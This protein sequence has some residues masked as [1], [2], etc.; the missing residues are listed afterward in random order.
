MLFQWESSLN[1]SDWNPIEGATNQN[2]NPP[3]STAGQIYY[4]ASL[5]NNGAACNDPESNSLTVIVNSLP[6]GSISG[7][8]T[9][10]NGNN[11]I[12]S[13]SVTGTGPWNGTLSD[14]TPFNSNTSPISVSV[15]PTSTTTYSIN[16]LRDALCSA[17]PTELSGS[18]TVTV[19]PISVGGSVNGSTSVCTGTNSTLLTLSGQIG[20]VVM[21]QFSVD[22]GNNWINDANTNTTY[23]ASN[24]TTTTQ[25]RVVIQSGICPQAFSSAATITVNPLLPVSVSIAASANPICVGNSVTFTAT[26]TNGG[27]SPTYRWQ[28]NGINVPGEFGSTF[29][30]LSITSGTV[31]TALLTSNATC[32]SQVTA[33]S[34][35]ISLIINPIPATPTASSNSPVCE[36]SSI[37]LFTPTVTGASYSWTGPNGFT[38][39]VQNPTISSSTIIMAGIYRV[40]VT[41]NG[42]TSLVGTTSVIINAIPSTP[43][44]SSNSPVCA[45]SIINLTTPSVAGATYSWTGP[46]GFTSANQNPT[47]ANSTL[48]MAGLYRVTVTVTGCPSLA[49]TTT[50]AINTIPSTPTASSNSPLCAGS[51]LN[52][53][54]SLVAG[55]TYFWTGPNGFTSTDQNP[56]IAT[57]TPSMAGGY[58]VTAIING[59]PSPAGTTSVVINEIPS[60][61]T[62]SSNSPVCAGSTINLT[63][64]SVAGATYSWTGPNGFTSTIQNPTI[65]NSTLAMAGLYS[66]TVTVNGC[67]SLAGTTTVAINTIPSTPTASSNS[68]LCAGSTLNLTS[69][70]VAG[71]TYSWTGPNGFTSANQNPTIANSTLA[72]AGVYSVTAI[73]N[74]CPSPAVTTSVVINA[75]PS[76]PTAS[77]NSPVCT[78]STINLTTPLVA[79]ATYSWTGPNGFT[80]TIQNPTIANSTLAMAGLYSVTVTVNGCPSLAGTTTVAINTIP[81]TPTASSNSPLC[82]GST[83]NLTSSLV[84]GA[85]YSWTGPNGFT[86]TNQNPTIANSTLAMAGVY[87][88]TATVNGC[89][90]LAGTTSVV[91][92]E[93]PS[94][95]TVS[96]NSPVCAGSTINLTT[97]SVT[98]ASYSWTAPNGFTSTNQNPTIANAT[99]A[100]AGLYSVTVTVNGCPSTTGTTSLVVNS[101][102]TP[103]VTISSSSTSIC[104]FAGTSVTFTAIPV[105]GGASPSYQWKNG[106]TNVGP[107]SSTYTVTSLPAGSVISVVMT[108]NATCPSPTTATSNSIALTVY[109]GVPSTPTTPSVTPAPTNICPPAI[110]SLTSSSTNATLYTWTLPTPGWNIVA[111]NGTNTITVDITGAALSGNNQNVYVIASNA[112][113]SSSASGDKKFKVGNSASVD[114]GID[115]NVCAGNSI[116]VV[117]TLLGISDDANW[118]APSGSFSNIVKTTTTISATYTPSISSGTI[119]L[120]LTPVNPG[121]TCSGG[122]NPDVMVVTVNSRPTGVLSGT[123]AICN[124]SSATLS[125]A[126]TGSGTISGT[127]SDGTTFSGTAPTIT[128]NVSPNTT[129]TYTI[130]TLTNGTCPSIAADRTGSATVTVNNRPTA[131]ISGTQAICNG[132][133]ATLSLA[134]TGS[135][136][137]SG[138]LSD[139]TTFSGTAPTITVNV[140]P[141]TTTTYTITTLTNGTCPSI[142]ADRTG[143]ATV[144]VNNR[145]TAILSGTQAICN[146]SSATL[147]LAVTGSGTI[148]GTL[149]DGTTFSGTAPTITINVSPNT[150]TTYTITTLTNGTCPSI[151]AD[152]TGSATVTVNN[153]PTAIL[154]GTQAICNGSSATLSLA[155]TGSGT[156]SG[157]LSDGTTFSGTAPTITIN[158]SPNTT[159]TYTI[160]TLTNGTCPSIA[161]DRTGSATVTVNNRPTATLSG[162]QAICNGSSATLSLAV[163]GSGTI[164]GTLSD[165]TTFSGTA[166]TITVNVSP[167]TTTTYTITTLTNGT[168]PSIAADRT[169]SATVTVNNRP[170]ATLSGT[171]AICN[172]SSATLSLAVTG[173]G[174]ISGTLSDGTTFSGTAPTI[175]VNVSPNTTTTYTI[176]TLTNGTCPSIVADR[177]GSA[178][179][180]VNNRPTAILS[181]TQAICN[182]SSATLSLAVTGSGTISGTLSD[183]TTFSG[184][185]P[186]ISINVSPNTT[187]SYTIATLTNGTCPSIAADRTGSAI[188]TVNQPVVITTE[189]N[190]SQTVCSSFPVSFTV[191]ATGTGITYQWYKDSNPLSN[192]PGVISGATSATLTL[193]QASVAQSGTYYAIVTGSAPCTSATS[194]NAQLTVNR[195]IDITADPISQ[196]AC[197]GSNITFTVVAT[198]SISSYVW[199]KDG[200]PV[201]NGNYSGVSTA[202]LTITGVLVSN[203]GNYDVVISSSS[204]NGICDQV[205]SA[206]ALLV[207]NLPVE[208]PIF[209]LGASSTRCQG[210]GIITYTA[211][212][213][214]STS[215]TYSLDAITL[216]FA[217][218]SIVA[219]TGAVTFAAGWSGTSIITASAAGCNGPTSSS[220]TVTVTPTVGTPTA[221]TISAGIEP[222][223]QIT[224][225]T[226]TT[227]YAT[228]ATNNTG[229]NWTLSNSAAGTIN[230]SGIM[231][232]TSGFS[233]TVDIQVTADGCNGPSSQVIRTVNITPTVSLPTPI[234]VA[235]GSEPICQLTNGTTTTTYSTSAANSSGFNWSLSNPA[236]GSINAITGVM[237]W[238]NGFS[239]SVNIQVTANGCN[240]PSAQVI[241]TVNVTP[242]IGTPTAIIVS[243]G[244]EPTCQITASTPN[245]TY[246]TT[247]TNN[248]GFNWTLSN[249]AAGIINSSGVVTWAPGFSGPVDIQVTANGC[250]GPSSQVIRTVNISSTVSLPT[251]IVIAAGSEPIC[252]LTNGTTTTTYS[253]TASNS[254]GFNWSL[255]NPAAGS[256]NAITGLM[257]WANGFSGSV[258]IQVT[259]NGCNGP[260][261]QVIRTVNV[262]PTVGTPTAIAVA[263][264][265]E[266]ACQITSS[267]P[268]TTYSSTATGGTGF[269]WTV[270]NAAAGSIN[271]TTGVMTWTPGFS[272]SV[273]IQVTANGCNGPSGQVIRT[274]NITQSVANPIFVLG[275]SSARCQGAGSVTYTA[276]AT[277]SAGITYTLDAA[278]LSGGN[279]INGSTGAVSYSAAWSGT[280]TI[281]ASAAGCNGPITATHIVTINSLSAGGTITLPLT[282]VC[283]GSNSGTL[284]LS[285]NSGSIIRW[286]SSTNGGLNWSSITNTS[287]TQNYTNL[288]QTTSYR[289]VIQSGVCPIV[290]SSRAIV[291]IISP[292]TPTITTVP[293]PPVICEGQSATLTASTGTLDGGFSSG[294]FANANP[295][296]WRRDGQTTGDFLPAQ[297]DNSTSGA[298]GET[299]GPRIFSGTNYDSR[300]GKFAIVDGNRTSILETPIFSLIGISTATLDWRQAFNLLSGSTALV[301]LSVDGGVTYNII[302]APYI[303]PQS[304]GPSDGFLPYSIDLSPYLGQSNLRVRFNYTGTAGS[305]WA[306][307]DVVIGPPAPVTPVTYE[308]GTPFIGTG[309]TLTVSPIVTTTYTLTATLNGC[310]LGSTTVTVTVNP[311]PFVTGQTAT[312]CSGGTFNVTPTDGGGNK[313][314]AGTTY[315][316]T[317]PISSPVGAITGGSAQ[318]TGQNSISQTLTNTTNTPATLTYTVAP[319]SGV[320]VGTTFTIVVTVNPAPTIINQTA[321]ICSGGT[322]NVTPANGGGNIVPTGTIYSWSAPI[323]TGGITGGASGIGATNISGTLTNPTNTTQ[324]ATYSVTA[325]SGICAGLPFTVTVNVNPV[326]AINTIIAGTCTGSSFTVSPVNTTNG[327]VPAGTTYSWPAPIVTGGITGGTSGSGATNIS[328]TL[329]N[330]TNTPQTATYTVTPTTGS[331]TG[332]P[333][334]L[335][336]T[337][338]PLPVA[339]I[340][341]DPAIIYVNGSLS[342]NGNP[343]GGSGTYITHL[344]TGT[345]AIYLSDPNIQNPVF[346]GAPAGTYNLTYTV[347]DNN[348]CIGSDNVIITVYGLPT[349]AITPV[350]AVICADGSL[351][352]NG[353]PSGGSGTYTTH[354]WTGTGAGY[355]SNV[356]IQNPL[357]TGAP[358][359]TYT[360]TYTVT[361][362]AGGVGISATINVIVNR[363]PSTSPIYHRQI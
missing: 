325:T 205:V 224:A 194:A 276:S 309:Q 333:F 67:P 151:V 53:T 222:T 334:T 155:V 235:A 36:G 7:T 189:P 347:T 49:G 324:T 87:S 93:I 100:M 114:A 249:S 69:S 75:I 143:S 219:S 304:A 318:G 90:S 121:G 96:S 305:S 66:V 169:G 352:M 1:N 355:L 25:Y 17:G 354:L 45:S 308:W 109:N 204:G 142:A 136:T 115:Q 344:W 218:N 296:G 323:V 158:V 228:T 59:C 149:S 124:G 280:T 16:S 213:I 26:P 257:T 360:L 108:S 243:A 193:P 147:S 191:G 173:S 58:S 265:T 127:L 35:S 125:L 33:T 116:T 140:S 320:C 253:T 43:T 46:N 298:W 177:T 184:S 57:S 40:I 200:I 2:Y 240:G 275:S 206:P 292:F 190:P 60:T 267:T 283:S 346:S 27:I 290:Y 145:P 227:T 202:T 244:T 273:N 239:G 332:Q 71:A 164:S 198:G 97:P 162:T 120:T 34:N 186:T 351:N 348:G 261:A 277:N 180:T 85:T 342:F 306:I 130:T 357:F 135:G 209:N 131:T 175:T 299:N 359:G 150:T 237:T 6:T 64:P 181:G 74:G 170:T 258:N 128:V 72:M 178:T 262:T 232:W 146:G 80:S 132:S 254:S 50:V 358:A 19:D 99:L 234:I 340:T 217:G 73:I 192:V 236:A 268:T 264:G 266:P 4:R 77:S 153:R 171:Q 297:R 238:A 118:S 287:N 188:I 44:V 61:P 176:T 216:A 343:S 310:P 245:T 302:L 12:L 10:C 133:S 269:N 137:I 117:G 172:G 361:D 42:C 24:L 83:L 78:G 22:G 76:T 79:G 23:T 214:H 223:C 201:S 13:I 229:F 139:G 39:N 285:G 187:T 312:I 241:R 252:Q 86:S 251:P 56:T 103:S 337:V 247:A 20:N 106:A 123:Q 29:S 288:T 94:T 289:A 210:A 161:A 102:L 329:T 278:S 21:W 157:T 52:L 339:A 356:N 185:A 215:V 281:T 353:N 286:E 3:S 284:T 138:T 88:V 195:D 84:A 110:I 319:R 98:G 48:A 18:A 255:N 263:A 233:G 47:I 122:V 81:S 166:P 221:I 291:S 107:N 314:P 113:G 32:P 279:S 294:N 9:I 179:V 317:N 335:I 242:T 11:A 331:C 70:L 196:S 282:I 14:G 349:A 225:S 260:S 41:V 274:V 54:S 322:F 350:P 104:S 141:N 82:A 65:A 89:P 199:R 126:V 300:D 259:A 363:L 167:N 51:T 183:G 156:I 159:T 271:P 345:G 301:E 160:T 154:S 203:A 163:T 197:G 338:N 341:P 62:V 230:S 144:T 295:P 55:A 111:G 211:T 8:Q 95:P 31:V 293:A 248:T 272:G 15:S 256:I 311:T 5:T 226:P 165:G 250:N 119:N 152:R 307:D 112:C 91:I 105:N 101:N 182:G 313:V 270:S 129:T 92:N 38:S 68:P 207:V 303:G 63:T 316:W 231:T 326:P 28:I 134:V 362:S 208:T 315:T 37:N 212:A 30:P 168:C 330:P 321:T 336:M 220:H 328:G 246:A 148:S 174:T 327:I